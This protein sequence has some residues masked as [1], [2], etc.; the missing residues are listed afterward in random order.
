MDGPETISKDIFYNCSECS[1]L[2]E[3]LFVD[4]DIIEFKCFNEKNP[5]KIKMPLNEYI[6][7]MASHHLEKNYDKCK[8]NEN[9]NKNYESYCLECNTHLCEECLNTGQ[10]LFHYKINMK[11]IVPKDNEIKLV[12]KIINIIDTKHE[13][14]ALTNFYEIVFN[15]F[16]ESSKH[17]YYYCIN[18][19]NI[20]MNYI[21]NNPSF[22][23]T[24]DKEEYEK[25][26]KIK[27]QIDK[28]RLLD[29]YDKMKLNYEM[30]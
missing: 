18:V 19:Y 22:R 3:V 13:F 10:H 11:E 15:T 8:I 2:I 20:L 9:H 4:K 6:E 26:I 16:Q 25:L 27:N 30:K 23:N 29:E 17:N 24:M 7:K 28:M 21:E 1:S 14:N 5:H 12:Q